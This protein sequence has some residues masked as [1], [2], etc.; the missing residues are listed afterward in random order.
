[1]GL[2]SKLSKF[3]SSPSSD[4]EGA[5]WVYV[6]CNRCGEQLRSRV[7]LYN[8]LSIDY[9]GRNEQTYICRKTLVGNQR[10]FQRIEVELKFDEK[11]N[12]LEREITGG[13][14]IVGDEYSVGEDSS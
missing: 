11:R 3:L 12:L 2:F 10:C 1:M 14:F 9:Q 13:E 8:D 6:C 4:D 7:N 5:Y